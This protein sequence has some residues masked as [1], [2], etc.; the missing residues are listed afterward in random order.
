MNVTGVAKQRRIVP[1]S[2]SLQKNEIVFPFISY[3]YKCVFMEQCQ[4]KLLQSKLRC[5]IL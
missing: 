5:V 3:M 4:K 2:I 1:T